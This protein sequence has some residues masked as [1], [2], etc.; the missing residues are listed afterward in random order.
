VHYGLGNLLEKTSDFS[1][2]QREY[3]AAQALHPDFPAQKVARRN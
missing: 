2:T 3:A 1:G